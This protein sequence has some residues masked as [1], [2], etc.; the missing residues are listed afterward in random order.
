VIGALTVLPVE[1][2]SRDGK[3]YCALYEFEDAELIGKL[4]A[5]KGNAN[6]ILSNMPGTAW[7]WLK[8][9]D[10]WQQ[11]YVGA[12]GTPVSAELRFWL[13]AA[14]SLAQSSDRVQPAVHEIRS[15]RAG[16]PAFATRGRPVRTKD[17]SHASGLP[18][19][20]HRAETRDE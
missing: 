7:T 12:D 18:H 14:D 8:T 4:K 13:G 19:G 10:S 6:V 2:A 20:G 1:A 5:L 16:V 9:D 3:V 17:V 15:R 11:H